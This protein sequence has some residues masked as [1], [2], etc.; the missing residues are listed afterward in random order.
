MWW[1]EKYGLPSNHELF[2]SQNRFDLTVKFFIDYFKKFPIEARRLDNG[3]VRLPTTGDDWIDSLEEQIASGSLP[4]NWADE[5]L[6]D[7]NKFRAKKS[8]QN[9]R[10]LVPIPFTRKPTFGGDEG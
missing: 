3:E 2:T 4:D 1:E 10:A 9:K 6:A 5:Q 8:G 7:I